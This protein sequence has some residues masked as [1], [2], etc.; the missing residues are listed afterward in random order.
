MTNQS[1][2]TELQAK[3]PLSVMS[4]SIT[5]HHTASVADNVGGDN[6]TVPSNHDSNT[7]KKDDKNGGKSQ[8]ANYSSASSSTDEEL[9][10]V[11][12]HVVMLFV[13][14]TLCM[15]LVVATTTSIDFYTEKDEIYS[16]QQG[17][18]RT[19]GSLSGQGASG[20]AQACYRRVPADLRADSVSTVPPTSPTLVAK[21]YICIMM[22][23]FIFAWI[24]FIIQAKTSTKFVINTNNKSSLC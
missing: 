20:G 21:V 13:P 11:A 22:G 14:V 9:M 5:D 15:L 7:L 2:Q 1:S 6:P 10:H 3:Q 8:K 23:T 16:P 18:H 12:K 17:D 19:S 4:N 24:Y